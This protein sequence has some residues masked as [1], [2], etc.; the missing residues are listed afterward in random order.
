MKLNAT[1]EMLPCS[2]PEV[3]NL[4]PFQPIDQV[5]GYQIML[6]DLEKDL[7]EITGFDR[8]SFQSQSGAQGEYAGLRT[9]RAYLAS[10][11]ESHRDVS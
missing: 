6:S 3:I 11:G 9:I 10:R 7:C 8:I 4:H 2:W 1:T 5:R